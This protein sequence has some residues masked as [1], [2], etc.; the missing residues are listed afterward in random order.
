MLVRDFKNGVE[1]IVF[2][3]MSK[4]EIDLVIWDFY[5]FEINGLEVFKIIG[6]EMD[7]FVVSM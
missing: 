5:V 3:M 2:L 4:Y 6:K 1:V 7:L